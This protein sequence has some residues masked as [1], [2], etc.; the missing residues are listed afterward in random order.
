MKEFSSIEELM[1]GADKGEL[2]WYSDKDF[3]G[4][5]YRDSSGNFHASA[6]FTEFK[7]KYFDFL[8]LKEISE[9]GD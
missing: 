4:L 6:A 5:M 7:P 1:A 9:R 2:C 8:T 3:P